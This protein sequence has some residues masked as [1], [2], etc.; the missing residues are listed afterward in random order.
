MNGVIQTQDGPIIPGVWLGKVVKLDDASRAK[1]TGK[2][3]VQ[4]PDLYGENLPEDGIPWAYPI[5]PA[6]IH[7]KSKSG[8]FTMPKKDAYVCIMF[9]RGDPNSPRWFGGWAPQGRLPFQ[10]TQGRGDK[11]PNTTVFRM[12]DGAMLKFVDGESVELY[13]GKS[14][15]G[16]PDGVFTEDGEHTEY[17][18]F[19]KF[20]KRQGKLTFRCKL[21]ID[22]Q[23]KGTV[24]IRA[25]QMQIRLAP[26]QES[27]GEGGFQTAPDS[28]S[29]KF[30][31]SVIDPDAQQGSRFIMEPG[32][33]LGRAREVKGFEDS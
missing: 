32:K 19:L 18:T 16:D 30:E 1:R 8:W 31:I 21:D 3:K 17:D 11:F 6:P 33:L 26:N 9:E 28:P 29:A 25:P 5:F 7:P 13:I 10:F 4:I 14:G 2:C 23:C 15:T 22:I 20:D 27:D 12:A 24:K